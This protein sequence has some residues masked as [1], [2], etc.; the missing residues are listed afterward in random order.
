M[1]RHTKGQEEKAQTTLLRGPWG[2]HAEVMMKCIAEI[3]KVEAEAKQH[4]MKLKSRNKICRDFG[5]S[6]STVSKRISSDIPLSYIPL[7][8]KIHNKKLSH[9][10]SLETF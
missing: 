6:L 7:E 1:S 8:E 3:N 2:K 9:I 5:L 4:G 10:Y